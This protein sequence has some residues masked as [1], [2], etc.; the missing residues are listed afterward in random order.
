MPPPKAVSPVAV[1]I[2]VAVAVVWS[3]LA[4]STLITRDYTALSIATPV[5]LL[6]TGALF[7]IRVRNGG[8]K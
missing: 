3:I 8:T 7:G 4:L 5:M 1:K 6:T 2:A